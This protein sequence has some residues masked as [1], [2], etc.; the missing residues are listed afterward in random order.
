MG[1]AAVEITS[2]IERRAR[3]G[4]L[5]ASQRDVALGLLHDLALAW[6]EITAVT[7]V[8]DRA[9]RALAN[10]ELGSPRQPPRGGR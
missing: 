3:E 9:V 8:R 6:L 1:R 4:D 7:P 10:A 2:A 5:D